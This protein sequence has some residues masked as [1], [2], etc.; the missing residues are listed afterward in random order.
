MPTNKKHQTKKKIPTRGT[1]DYYFVKAGDVPQ[2]EID[3][4]AVQLFVLLIEQNM[5]DQ[6]IYQL[7]MHIFL[8]TL[9]NIRFHMHTPHPK[10]LKEEEHFFTYAEEQ[11]R[12]YQR[13]IEFYRSQ[14]RSGPALG[15][16]R[17]PRPGRRHS[18]GA[19]R[20]RIKN[21]NKA[22]HSLTQNN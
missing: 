14:R 17:R 15:G 5:H 7:P 12:A 6:H 21:K 3:A 2:A 16:I 18:V 13:S 11:E 10:I 20:T 9:L 1:I 22:K 19:A 8:Y 4:E